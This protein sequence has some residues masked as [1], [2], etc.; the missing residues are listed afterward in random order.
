MSESA[1]TRLTISWSKDTDLALRSYL[2]SQG[3]KKGALSLF[4]EDAVKW[5]LFSQT[6]GEARAGFAGV[7]AA[8]LDGILNEAV[9]SVRQP[10]HPDRPG[11]TRK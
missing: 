11:R 2:G 9:K 10:K 7:D 8:E 6:V 1:V 4:I 3:L 5:R